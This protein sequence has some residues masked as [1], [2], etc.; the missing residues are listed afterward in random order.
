MDRILEIPGLS[1]TILSFLDKDIGNICLLSKKY[2]RIV[3]KIIHDDPRIKMSLFQDN[4]YC[5]CGLCEFKD[6]PFEFYPILLRDETDKIKFELGC[7]KDIINYIHELV[8]YNKK[9]SHTCWSC[10]VFNCKFMSINPTMFNLYKHKY[11]HMLVCI[12]HAKI[13]IGTNIFNFREDN[14]LIKCSRCLYESIII[15]EFYYFD[16]LFCYNC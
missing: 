7:S 1:T 6:S 12:L 10:E 3:S 15:N 4:Y 11:G 9:P 16:E 14:H 13:F 2:N 8:K 5:C